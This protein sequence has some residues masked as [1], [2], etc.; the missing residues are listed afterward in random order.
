MDLTVTQRII[1]VVVALLIVASTVELIRRRKLRE[2]YAILW[3]MASA[4]LVI[5]AV[6]PRLLWIISKALGVYYITMM[7]IACFAFLSLVVIHYAMAISRL[8]ESN[9]Q[10]A[11]RLALLEQSLTD[12][13]T[14]EKHD[15]QE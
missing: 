14:V 1:P 8:S 7:M 4:V 15:Q 5:F 2:E 10:L 3:L 13:Q 6:F 11:Q 9:R 12:Q